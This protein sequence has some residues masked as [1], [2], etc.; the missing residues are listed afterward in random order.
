MA[1]CFTIA[2]RILLAASVL[3]ASS[4]TPGICH[5]HDDGDRPHVHHVTPAQAIKRHRHEHAHHEHA[6]AGHHVAGDGRHAEP[7][8]A[9]VGCSQCQRHLH[10]STW[11][12]LSI[13]LPSPS[14]EDESGDGSGRPVTMVIVPSSDVTAVATRGDD[15]LAAMP[16]NQ[17]A[18]LV[19]DACAVA[20][21]QPDFRSLPVV[22]ALL[23]DTA[24][25]ERSGVQL[26]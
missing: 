17:D 3:L 5:A 25:H 14:D 10:F 24:R 9:T 16:L 7:D 21:A 18:D 20:T 13:T 8:D 1:I 2:G 4:G 12:G 11:F 22:A 26:S 23:C 19:A 6:H 15:S